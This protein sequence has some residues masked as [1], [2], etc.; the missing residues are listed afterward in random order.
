MRKKTGIAPE[1]EGFTLVELMVV[2][3]I[4]GLLATL[5]ALTVLPNLGKAADQKARA[6]KFIMQLMFA[7]NVANVLAQETLDALAKFLHAVDVGLVHPP[8]AIGR[9]GRP[10]LE[11]LDLLLDPV[12]PRHVGHQ[13]FN[14]RKR[15]QRL[16]D[17]RQIQG[18]VR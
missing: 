18:H 1:E 15:P 6:D 11:R 5:V 8:G 7:Q 10:R 16:Q 4:I 14:K 3:V 17:H 9:V 13:I 12:V 2:I